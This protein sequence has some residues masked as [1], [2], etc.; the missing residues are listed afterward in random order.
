MASSLAI[1]MKRPE[2][3]FISLRRLEVLLLNGV[4]LGAEPMFDR[5][6]GLGQ[7]LA[8]ETKFVGTP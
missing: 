6:A 1:G 5:W 3:G 7:A 8:A 2:F 4:S